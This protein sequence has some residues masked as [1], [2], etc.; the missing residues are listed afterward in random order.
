M[1]FSGGSAIKDSPANTGDMGLIPSPG[2]PGGFPGGLDSK[3]SACNAGNPGSIPGLERV[4][5]GRLGNPLQHSCLE[6]PH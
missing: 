5:G 2:G 3:E 1:D 6:N 4:P